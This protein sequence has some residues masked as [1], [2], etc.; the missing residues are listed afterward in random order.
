MLEG[1]K[2]LLALIKKDNPRAD[3][4]ATQ[5]NLDNPSEVEGSELSKVKITAVTDLGYSGDITVEYT[6][7]L[8]SEYINESDF[9]VIDSNITLEELKEELANRFNIVVDDIDINDFT[10]TEGDINQIKVITLSSVVGYIYKESEEIPIVVSTLEPDDETGW[11][12]VDSN[13]YRVDT[14]G[15]VRG[16]PYP[17]PNLN[18]YYGGFNDTLFN[19]T[20]LIDS[21]LTLVKSESNLSKARTG[22]A[23]AGL[24]NT[25]IFTGGANTNGDMPT[26][27][28]ITLI[29]SD[30]TLKGNDKGLAK[31]IV[32][33]SGVGIIDRAIFYGGYQVV[34]SNEVSAFNEDG[35]KLFTKESI[36]TAR[37]RLASTNLNGLGFF[38]SGHNGTNLTRTLSI[39]N[40]S[41]S[42]VNEEA[43]IGTARVMAGGGTADDIAM[44]FGGEGSKTNTGL[45]TRINISGTMVGNERLLE[46]TSLRG[47]GGTINK[48]AIF[49]GQDFDTKIMTVTAVNKDVTVTSNN[50]KLGNSREGVGSASL[51]K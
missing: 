22:V 11:R 32:N 6:R 28:N 49:Y 48:R 2:N 34:K 36:G 5:V 13:G 27:T 24:F 40:Y 1:I 38:F 12:G 26:E 23:G 30:G 33:H 17:L 46:T 29:N 37:Y 19:N 43:T 7:R 39:I 50:V 41:G 14:E 45:L 15:R 10:V 25:G 8:L 42:L 3:I 16:T 31:S 21:S 20:T 47:G 4:R 51:F 9:L 35:D 44:F 18:I